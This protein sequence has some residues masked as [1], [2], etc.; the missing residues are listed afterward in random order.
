MTRALR[1]F[2]LVAFGLLG[3]C[4]PLVSGQPLA[5]AS[6]PQQAAGAGAVLFRLHVTVANHSEHHIA[7]MFLSFER[8]EPPQRQTFYMAEADT[9]Q[10]FL[11]SLPPGT[12]RT[13]FEVYSSSRLADGTA[14]QRLPASSGPFAAID[15]RPGAVTVPGGLTCA[16]EVTQEDLRLGMGFD[17]TKTKD[18]LLREALARPEAQQRGWGRALQAALATG[19]HP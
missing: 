2:V 17:A 16:V 10:V 5:E 15:V 18:D 6:F 4:T 12:Y 8:S 14:G 13:F 9:E 19:D 3:D 11:L 1:A 7:G